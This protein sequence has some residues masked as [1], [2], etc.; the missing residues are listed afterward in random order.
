MRQE[1]K[2]LDNFEK[3]EDGVLRVDACFDRHSLPRKYQDLSCADVAS[4]SFGRSSVWDEI[5]LL[6]KV[7]ILT[8]KGLR[9][10]GDQTLEDF[11]SENIEIL[12]EVV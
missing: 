11:V 2:N 10:R 5:Y 3:F 8:S 6:N 9:P 7:A 4:L 12:G 1:R